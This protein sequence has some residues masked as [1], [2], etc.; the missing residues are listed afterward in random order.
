MKYAPSYERTVDAPQ[1]NKE[2]RRAQ[3]EEREG[4]M[5]VGDGRVTG[6][7]ISEDQGE[8]MDGKGDG[9]KIVRGPVQ[10][11]PARGQRNRITDGRGE[12]KA[13]AM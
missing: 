7:D 10:A 13:R 5:E 12:V 6:N 2:A 4:F 8:E 11:L 3:G 9:E 1:K